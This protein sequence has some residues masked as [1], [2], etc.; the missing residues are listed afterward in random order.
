MPL[1]NS[2]GIRPCPFAGDDPPALNIA[3]LFNNRK[4]ASARHEHLRKFYCKPY[5]W[6]R[7]YYVDSVGG[8]L[9]ETVKHYVEAQ[10][11]NERAKKAPSG[12]RPLD[13]LL[14]TSLRRECAGVM[15]KERIAV[16]YHKR[17]LAAK[18]N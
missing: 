15:F 13:P 17:W 9:L 4:S 2:G 3:V 12:R 5:F 14:A 7:A 8:S 16:F 6:H 10:G 18:K 11:V 1:S